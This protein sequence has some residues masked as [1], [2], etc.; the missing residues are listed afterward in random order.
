[1]PS[2]ELIADPFVKGDLL[3][4]HGAVKALAPR[5][6]QCYAC[7]CVVVSLKPE[8]LQQRGVERPPD[9]HSAIL[10]VRIDGGIR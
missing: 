6:W 7:T 5:I 8:N 2:A 4:T 10:L 3:E 1:M 9:A